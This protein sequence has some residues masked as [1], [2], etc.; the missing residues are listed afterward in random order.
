MGRREN[1]GLLM[2]VLNTDNQELNALIE[3]ARIDVI[4]SSDVGYSKLH[5][6]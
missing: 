3:Q 1:A 6:S 4:S 2:K 5:G